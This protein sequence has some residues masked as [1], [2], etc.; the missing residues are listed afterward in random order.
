MGL[1]LRPVKIQK[2]ILDRIKLAFEWARMGDVKFFKAAVTD[3]LLDARDESGNSLLH[4]VVLAKRE[5]KFIEILVKRGVPI[6]G[7]N[8]EGNTALHLAVKMQWVR[9]VRKLLACG[10][11][12]NIPNFSGQVPAQM[13]KS[14][15][16]Q[17]VFEEQNALVSLSDE[18]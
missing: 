9:F 6:D 3:D 18:N 4:A 16:I 15:T 14:K 11:D 2:P 12:M 1:P 10:A 13:N 17:Q 8:S 7:I 5:V